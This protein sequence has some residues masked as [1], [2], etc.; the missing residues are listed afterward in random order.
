MEHC[1]VILVDDDQDD[2]VFLKYALEQTGR[3]SIVAVCC[4]YEELMSVLDTHPPPDL[5]VSDLFMPGRSGIEI[6]KKLQQTTAYSKIPVVLLTGS[7]P[8][9]AIAQAAAGYG[10]N[11]ILI[12]P[13]DLADYNEVTAQ[14]IDI[15]SGFK[16][17]S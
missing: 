13:D 5:I 7:K 16:S 10:A 11:A 9:N 6:C 4:N 12:K 3:I 15:C 17:L 2:L 8:T 14:L 1:K